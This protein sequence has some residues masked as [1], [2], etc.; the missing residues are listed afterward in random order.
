MKVEAFEDEF[1][2]RRHQAGRLE[3]ADRS[4]FSSLDLAAL[5]RQ[6]VA[7]IAPW[8][9]DR[10]ASIAFVE[11]GPVSVIGNRPLIE[12]A[13]RN[14]IENAVKHT[15]KGAAIE[16]SVGPS[17]SLTVSDDAGLLASP[18]QA[19]PEPN[20]GVGMGLEIVRRIMALHRGRLEP[21]VRAGARTSMRLVFAERGAGSGEVGSKI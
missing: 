17:E 21:A 5:G 9:Y 20:D 18:E 4:G 19:R 8:V 7:D 12:D 11:H 6:T 14:L 1:T 15:P 16:V 13:I 2:R 10:Q 3:C